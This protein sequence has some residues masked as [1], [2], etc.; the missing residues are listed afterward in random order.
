MKSHEL[1]F[2]KKWSSGGCLTILNSSDFWVIASVFCFYFTY[3]RPCLRPG[4]Q[5]ILVI[6]MLWVWDYSGYRSRDGRKLYSCIWWM[7]ICT[8]TW[9]YQMNSILQ[10]YVYEWSWWGLKQWFATR[11]MVPTRGPWK[12]SKGDFIIVK[13]T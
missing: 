10:H 2:Y 4:T 8:L 1:H 5:Q 9:T 13:I 6:Q 11:G 7:Q 12:T 3:L